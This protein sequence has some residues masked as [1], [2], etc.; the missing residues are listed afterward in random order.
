M[1]KVKNINTQECQMLSPQGLSRYGSIKHLLPFG[2]TWFELLVKQGRAPKKIRLGNRCTFYKNSEI[3][4]FLDDI[5]NYRTEDFGD[6]S[7]M[8]V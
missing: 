3:L 5:V 7:G 8:G 4:K 2:K 1:N 6:Y